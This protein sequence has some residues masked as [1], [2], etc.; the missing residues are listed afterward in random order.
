MLL[1]V[2]AQPSG[3][4]PNFFNAQRKSAV[5]YYGYE[6]MMKLNNH[7]EFF[8]AEPELNWSELLV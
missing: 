3:S 7:Y 2:E 6:H 4:Y 1:R 5:A 8:A